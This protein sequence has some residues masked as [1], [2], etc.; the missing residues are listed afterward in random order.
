MNSPGN[1]TILRSALRFLKWFCPDHLYEEIEGDLIQ[2]FEKDVKQFRELRAS[3]RLIWNA[4]R[5]FRPGI[6]FRNKILIEVNQM[7]M[8]LNHLKFATRIFLKDKF[9]S[10]LNILGLAL[11]ISV[12]LVLLLILQNDLTYDQHY[13]NHKRI[14]RLGCHYQ[15]TGM[16]EW[17]ARTARELGPILKADFPEVQAIVPVKPMDRTLVKYE[18]K[19][20]LKIFYEE[21]VIHTDST[22]FRVFTHYFISGD[23]RTCM[24]D[25][26]ALVITEST[27]RK[28]FGEDDPYDKSLLIDN[29]FWKVTAVIKDLPENSHLKF[30]IALSGL[31]DYREWT[32]KEGRP[33]SE[34]FWNPDVYMY[35]FVPENYDPENFYKKWPAIY[36]KYFKETGDQVSGKNAP[37][38]EP[39][40][41]IHFYSDLQDN[42]PH[43]NKAFLYAITCI[44]ILI[45]LLACI[46]YMNL[47]TAK[48]ISRTKEIMIKKIVGSRR[49]TMVLSF[50]SESILLSF[51]SMILAIVIVFLLLNSTSFNLLIG[52]N[53]SLDFLHNQVLLFGTIGI[54]LGIGFLSGLYPAFYL[55]G[56]PTIKTLKG[57]FKNSK[58]SLILRKSLITIQFAISIF[59]VVCTLFMHDQINFV[60]N[61]D[62]G[63]DKDNLLVLPIL[64]TLVFNKIPT[65]KNELLLNRNILAVT[66]AQDV[67]GMGVGS[68]VMYGESETGMKQEG[69]VLCLFVGD[70]YLKTMGMTL[71]SG[72]DFQPG[73]KVDEKGMYIANESAVELMGWGKNALGKK[74]HFWGGEN[75][76]QVIGVVKDFNVNSLYQGVDPMFIV[77]G[78]WDKGFLQIR[79]TGD[80]LPE[81]I[82]YIKDKW[83]Q[84]DPNHPF[85]FFFLDQRFNEQ[86]KNDV[87][88]NKL[89]SILS[90][91]CIFISL[92]GLL[93]LSAFA[94]TQR[95]KEIGV[96]KVLGA[97][98]PDIIL[99][100]SK[101]VL[102]LVILS[103]ILV[104][105]VSWWVITRWME[106]F[107][108]KTQLDYS[109]YLMVTAL[110]LV[111]VFLTI[112]IQSL[113]T[114]RSNPV[115]S[116]KYE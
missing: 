111:F 24:N 10:T 7:D 96:R 86:Y 30:D 16:D 97:N 84:Y 26:H 18:S 9:F 112:M 83:S 78:H 104:V 101:D 39:L 12:S 21:N 67:M 37:I 53:L 62:L 48:S 45:I 33:I 50:L 19:E 22:Y 11:G 35:L 57:A 100:L 6:L 27:A 58:S 79:L 71:I 52:K 47:S 106:N 113:K 17:V 42:E 87:L 13:P 28:Y 110:S 90:F 49:R 95:T 103:A 20:N 82:K 46:N 76:G 75:A 29:T 91:I 109:L 55:P 85:E 51:I 105:P 43:G 14:Y 69:G 61:K 73:P 93:G 98:I 32:I 63:F 1:H 23:V 94:A 38:L 59:V 2:K 15:I 36:A 66:A 89:L 56:M 70:D 4:I 41:N 115:D 107:A 68:S 31:P 5:F 80:N 64:D 72:R 114:A 44:G 77:K 74:V 25:P 108:Y 92:L 34:A 8:L 3:R 81:T 99:L 102:L 88:Q 116:L 65:V 40:A 60:Q 54:T